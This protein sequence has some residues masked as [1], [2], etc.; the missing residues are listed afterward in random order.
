LQQRAPHQEFN[1]N[2]NTKGLGLFGQVRRGFI[3]KL[4]ELEKSIDLPLAGGWTTL[5][6]TNNARIQWIGNSGREGSTWNKDF[7]KEYIYTAIFRINIDQ[8][9]NAI[10]SK[11][12][13][14]GQM[15]IN[16]LIVN[17]YTDKYTKTL[18]RKK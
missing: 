14:F 5:E 10:Y 11:N 2:F 18:P 17:I 3:N 1:E 4:K 6:K 12:F 16:S 9:S 7:Y 13:G 15:D 8:G